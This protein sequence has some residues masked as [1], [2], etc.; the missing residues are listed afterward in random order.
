MDE[1]EIKDGD[2]SVYHHPIRGFARTTDA[3]TYG[4]SA[5]DRR[6]ARI[7]KFSSSSQIKEVLTM[8]GKV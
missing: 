1:R 8:W 7:G 2:T 6:G 5:E 4:I 3:A